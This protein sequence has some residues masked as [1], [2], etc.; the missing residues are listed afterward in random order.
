[1]R[2]IQRGQQ[3]RQPRFLAPRKPSHHRFS[4]LRHQAKARQPRAQF[5]LAL[6]GPQPHD[7][8]Q[9]GLVDVQLVHLMLREIADAKL[10]RFGHLPLARGKL[11]GQK[12]RQRRFAL[13]VAAQK[14]D[15]VILIDAQAQLAQDRRAAIPD[16]AAFDV[17]D[18]RRQL[19]GRGEGEDHLLG[20]LGRGDRRHLLQHLDAR[21]RLYSFRGLGFKP[22]HE[23]LQMGAAGLL[24]F[25]LGLQD[26][27]ALGHLAGELVI[28][29]LPIGQLTVVQMQNSLH[30]AVQ[31]ATI[32]AD[33]QHGM[34]I[35]RQIAFQPQSTFEIEIVGRFVQQK[36]I[37]LGK[38]HP[39]QSHPHPPA[40]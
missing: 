37:G 35:F 24:L 33:D 12:L 27:A 19:L 2:R 15:P 3:E 25:R 31:K 36:V 29:A 14:R 18:R 22:I 38:Q 30:G 16:S 7:V 21:L 39:R 28:A 20:I 40:A 10:G 13:A 5:R 11:P 34:G 32:M 9:R 4:L 8:L 26:G 1:M 17:D 23:R 6:S